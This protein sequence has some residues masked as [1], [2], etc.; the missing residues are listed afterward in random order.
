MKL[1]A[2]IFASVVL[3]VYLIYVLLNWFYFPLLSPKSNLKIK[4]RNLSKYTFEN[5]ASHTFS[6]SLIKLERLLNSYPEYNSYLFSFINDDGKRVT[7]QANIPSRSL[8]PKPVI[9]VLIRGYV[10]KEIYTTGTGTKNVA[11]V[12]AKNG[13][14]TFAP[15]FVGY[16]ESDPESPDILESRF[17][18]PATVLS[19][20]AALKNY[21]PDFKIGIWAHSNGGQIALSVLEISRLPIPTTLW[22]PVSLGF[23]DSILNYI[24]DLPDKGEYIKN[25]LADFKTRFKPE[26]FSIASY[27]DRIN[28]PI[29]L[30]QGGKDDAVPK[31]W[32]DNLANNLSLKYYYYPLSDH[33]LHPDWNIAISR[34]L[35]FFKHYLTN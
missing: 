4:Q 27:F 34:D 18:K 2:I 10:D 28:A 9:I 31:D 21:R 7:G 14:I 6:G 16:G 26:E 15:D 33:N 13:Y 3:S 30:H 29:Q 20:L 11:A 25:D 1:R 24:N 5:I 32:S 22:A 23:P 19:L 12:F 17:E 8:N 35:A